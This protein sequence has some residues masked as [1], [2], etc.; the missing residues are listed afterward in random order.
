MIH[1]TTRATTGA[2]AAVSVV[3][4]VTAISPKPSNPHQ[5]L[6]RT[7]E[8]T[9]DSHGQAQAAADAIMSNDASIVELRIRRV[10]VTA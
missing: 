3:W 9:F 7:V 5:A 1:E 4:T 2:G 6:R 10:E 8:R